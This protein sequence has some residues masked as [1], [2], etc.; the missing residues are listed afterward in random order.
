MGYLT[1]SAM[2]RYHPWR[3]FGQNHPEVSV[4]CRYV[5]PNDLKGAWTPHGLYLHRDLDQVGRRMTLS[6]ELAHKERGSVCARGVTHTMTVEDVKEERAVDELASRKLITLDQL[7][8]ALAW[9][10][11]EVGSESA[12]EL[13]CDIHMLLIRVQNLTPTEK[14]HIDEELERRQP[15]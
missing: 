3:E 8:D 4:S 6:H 15:W 2:T 5:L 11:Y 1:V 13:W 10:R 14:K 9:T 12:G 7:I